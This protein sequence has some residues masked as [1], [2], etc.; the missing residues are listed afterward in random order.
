MPSSTAALAAATASST[1]SLRFFRS[2]SVAAPTLMTATPPDSLA[3]RSSSFSR[4]QSESVVSISASQ[5]R[6]AVGDG[7]L[8]ARRRRRSTVLSLV[9]TTRRAEP[10][11]SRP[12]SRSTRPTSGLTTWP[13][14]TT[15]RSSRNALRRS[16]KN[17]ALTATALS[18]LRMALTTSVDSASPSTSSAMISSGLPDLGDLL[19]QRQQVRQRA[20]LVAVQ[21]HQRRPRAPL[22]ASRSR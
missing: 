14:V 22:P 2:V 12:A 1:A 18:V 3:R 11:T 10:S 15:A 4:S 21:Q 17:G 7:V 8:G 16:P 13:P 6:L 20:D 5:L 9:T 19:Q